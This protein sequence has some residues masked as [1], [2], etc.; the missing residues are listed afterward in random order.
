MFRL[1]GTKALVCLVE[2]EEEHGRNLAV[3]LFKTEK[4]LG[5]PGTRKE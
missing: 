1:E 3:W 4:R 2:A 5:G